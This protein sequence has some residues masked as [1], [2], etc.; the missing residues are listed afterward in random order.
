MERQHRLSR[1]HPQTEDNYRCSRKVNRLAKVRPLRLQH[2][3][4]IILAYGPIIIKF[5]YNRKQ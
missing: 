1:I 2:V 3:S 4:S 5:G